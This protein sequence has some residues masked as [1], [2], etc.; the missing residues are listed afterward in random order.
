MCIRY[1]ILLLFCPLTYSMAQQVNNVRA[2][3]K[4]DVIYVFYDLKSSMDNQKYKISLY[5]SHN[6]Q[7]APVTLVSGNIGDTIT[8]GD[9]KKIEWQ[10]KNELSRYNGEITFEVQATLVY[11][12][13]V[14]AASQIHKEYKRT[15]AH[16]FSWRGGVTDEKIR[17]ELFNGNTR[18]SQTEDVPNKKQY[19]LMIPAHAKPGEYYRLK[20]TTV[21]HPDNYT[22]SS[23][24][25]VKRRYSWPVKLIPAAAAVVGTVIYY[26]TRPP[27]RRL[28]A[29]PGLPGE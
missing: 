21:N 16:T 17:I 8:A 29:P 14:M 22:L 1:I 6:Q 2:E 10:A 3:A 7:E 26:I 4:G 9:N 19:K 27:D 25:A 13:L 5:S 20:V 24:F 15:K 11:S 28:P 12:P 23:P 18:V